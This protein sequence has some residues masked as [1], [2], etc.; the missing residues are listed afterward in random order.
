[1][2]TF[3]SFEPVTAFSAPYPAANV[4][5]IKVWRANFFPPERTALRP[6]DDAG[7]RP[8]DDD[9]RNLREY[10]IRNNKRRVRGSAPAREHRGAS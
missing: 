1:M 4:L 2:G 9:K 5:W 10:I 6:G 3:S 8:G 7:L